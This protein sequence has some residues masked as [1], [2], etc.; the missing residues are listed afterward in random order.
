MTV[1]Q[2]HGAVS[3]LNGTLCGTG[4]SLAVEGGV[5]ADWR[6]RPGDGLEHHGGPDDLVVRAVHKFL[7]RPDGAT[8]TTRSDW[9]AARGLKT[10]SAAAAAL[11]RAASDLEGQ[12]LV[13][14]AVWCSRAAGVT[15]TGAWDDQW[16]VTMPGAHLVDNDHGHAIAVLAVA[17]LPV[18]VW[19]PDAAIPKPKAATVPVPASA[20]AEARAISELIR[21]ADIMAAMQRNG[22]LVHKL[23]AAAGLP[24]TDK[25]A[26][27]AM[28]AGALAASITGTGPAV[29][30]LFEAPVP[31]PEVAGGAWRWTR[32][33]A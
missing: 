24:V 6:W 13:D 33:V 1:G 17:P 14:A 27:V 7:G 20:K 15:L 4:C 5:E 25:P 23:Y 9:P 29:A 26:R 11:L 28:D 31:L 10:S 3:L 16:A 2:A 19:V 8:V 18:A 32:V 22:R 21:D 12:A 30:A